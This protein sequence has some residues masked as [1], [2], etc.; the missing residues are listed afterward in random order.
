MGNQVDLYQSNCGSVDF[1]G[2][3]MGFESFS[4]TESND[5]KKL[6]LNDITIEKDCEFELKDT[7]IDRLSFNRYTN[8]SENVLFDFVTVTDKLD[9]KHVSFD[10]ERF[11]HFDISKPDINI[12][13]SSFN[14][15]FFNSVKWGSISDKRYTATRDIFR[16]L[17]FF[18]EQQK[19]YIDADGFY[20][21][22]M[23]EQKKE[24]LKE[25][26]KNKSFYEKINH[27]SD[28]AVFYLHEHSSNFSQSWWLPVIWLIIIGMM[29]VI[30][31]NFDLSANDTKVA[32]SFSLI[33]VIFGSLMALLYK[34]V[35]Q[36]KIPAF[37]FKLLAFT[38]I[39]LI[40]LK[41]APDFLN[42]LAKM[43]NPINMFKNDALFIQH[44]FVSLIYRILILFLVYQLIA[45]IK[46]KV[47]S[48]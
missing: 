28:L 47:R 6:I 45:S 31:K 23:K 42:D 20:S 9:I 16:Q 29:G 43:L 7:R 15:N 22:E 17:K 30:F 1:S 39:L 10:K 44:E 19:N 32:I 40:S 5:L 26:N 38:A 2:V 37:V 41:I 25:N 13:N 8:K 3:T 48:K 35:V 36:K 24:L 18:S 12:K 27:F 21:L 34:Y 33:P 11:N 14:S 46:K 4:I